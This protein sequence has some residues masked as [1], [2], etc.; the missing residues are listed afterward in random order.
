LRARRSRSVGWSYT[1][2]ARPRDD[3]GGVVQSRTS[4]ATDRRRHYNDRSQERHGSSHLETCCVLVTDWAFRV[5]SW[6]FEGAEAGNPRCK[7][8]QKQRDDRRGSPTQRGYDANHNRR[9]IQCFVR[10]GW[11]CVDCQWE[12][13]SVRDFRLYGLGDPPIEAILEELR[14]RWHRNQKHL[15]GD[16]DIPIQE[17]PDLRLDLDNYRTR[18]N[19]CHSAKTLREQNGIARTQ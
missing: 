17:R 9:R 6:P 7:S 1:C 11:K 13:D 12:P 18:C 5:T 10:D 19:E 14:G 4:D 3:L 16:H 2:G 15:H 8:C